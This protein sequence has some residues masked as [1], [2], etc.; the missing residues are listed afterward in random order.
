M[1]SG[2]LK[3][4][5]L[6]QAKELLEG[7]VEDKA[8]LFAALDSTGSISEA[9]GTS[10]GVSSETQA[11]LDLIAGLDKAS[12]GVVE[13]ARLFWDRGDV[14]SLSDAAKQSSSILANQ[15]EEA[16]VHAFQT[17]LFAQEPTATIYGLISDGHIKVGPEE[18]K[19]RVLETLD[20]AISRGVNISKDH[21]CDLV[22]EVGLVDDGTGK[23]TRTFFHDLVRL[24]ALVRLP[25]DLDALL[26]SPFT[27]AHQ[28]AHTARSSFITAMSHYDLP[29]DRA[30][31]IHE[32]ATLVDMRN[33]QVWAALMASR[34]DVP[35][36]A[37]G[38]TGAG[39]SKEG[40]GE[41]QVSS[42]KH[43]A[44]Y[45]DMFASDM[46]FNACDDCNS[47]TSPAA[48]FVD[49]LRML[50]NTLS[51]ASK[52]D[53]PTLLGKLG[54]RR[55]DLLTLQLSCVNTNVLIPYIDLA[56]EAME[57]FISNAGK[58]ITGY[59][60]TDQ[61]SSEISLSEP[62]HT[63]Y[64]VYSGQMANQTFPLTLFPY[65]QA[66]DFQRLF[67]SNIDTSLA[68]IIRV[69]GSELKLYRAAA[70]GENSPEPNE[71]Q[72]RLCK[73]VL[74]N[75]AAAEYL[76]LS[77][78]DYLII[79]GTS[80][81][82]LDFMKA[83]VDS[84]LDQ[85]A[86][87][88]K[89]GLQE[90]AKYWGYDSTGD[91]LSESDNRG[92]PFVKAQLLVRAK[93][94]VEQLLELLKARLLQNQL[95][96][97]NPDGSAE[98]SGKI[99][100]LRLRH[101][102]KDNPKAPI[103]EDDCH[104]LQ[105]TI[106]MWRKT[107]WTLQDLDCALVSFGAGGAKSGYM[108]SPK[109][110]RAMA[111]IQRISSLT[112]VEISRLMPL[113]GPMDTN[114]D[115]SLYARLFLRGKAQRRDSVFGPDD[116][117]NYLQAGD[118]L[119]A[120]R[121]PLLA[122]FALDEKSLLAIVAFLDIADDKLDLN[123]VTAIY[124]VSLFC[125]ILSIKG[126]QFASFQ[127]LLKLEF[128]SL[129]DPET[130]L[131]VIKTF[132]EI[133]QDAG[134][135][136]EQLLLF[137]NNDQG[138]LA[139]S[140]EI[141]HG[142][143]AQQSVSVASDLILGIQ[144]TEEGLP[145]FG[146]DNTT[147]SPSD[148]VT[149]S[150]KLFDAPTA[151]Q[152]DAFIEMRSGTPLTDTSV[153]YTNVLLPFF[154][155]PKEAHKIFFEQADPTTGTE[156]EK[157]IAREKMLNSRRVYFL[158]A[159]LS[160]LQTRLANEAVLQAITSLFSGADAD[161]DVSV[162]RRLLSTVKKADS[163]NAAILDVLTGLAASNQEALAKNS[164][165]V[166][167][168]PLVADS[169]R[170][171]IPATRPSRSSSPQ[172]T[173]DGTALVFEPANGGWRSGQVSLSNGYAYHLHRSDGGGLAGASFSTLR[174]PSNQAFPQGTLV[175]SETAIS[176]Q[177]QLQ[178]LM[179]G[180]YVCSVFELNLDEVQFFQLE[181]AAGTALAVDFG[182]V[183]YEAVRRLQAYGEL[184]AK[185]KRPGDLLD[186]LKWTANSARTG[187]LAGQIA[188]ILDVAERQV[189]EYLAQRFAGQKEEQMIRQFQGTAEL[190]RL[191]DTLSF[192]ARAGVPG[193]T[194][195]LLFKLATPIVPPTETSDF[196]SA[197]RLR[198][199]LR[200]APSS[201]NG[202]SLATQV[203]GELRKNQ[204]AALVAYLLQQPCIVSRGIT[205]ADGLFEFLLIDVQ[206]G[207]CLQTSRIKQAISTIQL[208]V[209]RCILGLEKDEQVA[210][211]TV[212]L[213]RWKWMEG[214][215]LWE[216]NRKV[217]L[218]PENW[219]EA[220]LR[221][222][223]TEVFQALESAIMQN[224]IN[225]E[226]IS[227][228][229]K[230]YVYGVDNIADLNVQAYLW[231]KGTE[232]YTGTFHFFGRTRTAPYIHYYRTLD[233]V[234]SPTG[235]SIKVFWQ[236]WTKIDIQI[237]VYESDAEGKLLK[238][239]GSYLIPALYGDRLFLFC[240]HISVKTSPSTSSNS[241]SPLEIG[242]KKPAEIR[243][244]K[245]WQMQIGWTELR[246]GKWTPKQVS[247]ATLEIAGAQ[248]SVFPGMGTNPPGSA[249]T[250]AQKLPDI[251]SFKFW[252][253][254]R[255]I[256]T[257]PSPPPVKAPEKVNGALQASTSI[258]VIDVERW[259]DA[260]EGQSHRHV[261]YPLGRFEMRGSAGQVVLVDLNKAADSDPFKK[262]WRPTIPTVFTKMSYHKESSSDRNTPDVVIGRGESD[263]YAPQ[264]GVVSDPVDKMAKRD[265]Q[266][267][268]SFDDA[269]K[270][271]ATG[272]FQD[273]ITTESTISYITYPPFDKT[274]SAFDVFQH[275]LDRD[276]ISMA[277]TYDGV[278]HIYSFLA[279][280]SQDEWF[281]A[282]GKRNKLVN[283]LSTPY[284]I[285]NWELGAHAV[286]LLMERLQ[287]TQQYDLALQVAHYV[288]DPTIDGDSLGRC[289]R[290]PP[291]RELAEA[292]TPI[293][294]VRE[295]LQ[296]LKP[297]SGAEEEM[298]TNILQ[299]RMNPFNPHNVARGRPQ[300]YMR[301]FVMKYIEILVASGDVYFRQNTLEA[302]PLAINRYVE[303]SHV[304]GSAPVQ[305]PALTKPVYK[306][307]ADL[308][309]GWNDFSNANM[310]LELDFPFYSD[311]AT[312]GSTAAAGKGN[313]LQGGGVTGILKSTYF[314]VPANPKLMG[315]RNLIDD[316][317]FKIRNCQDINGLVRNL[318]LFEP[319]LDPGLLVRATA[320]GADISKLVSNL[321]GPMPNYRFQYLLQR[322]LEMCAEVKAMGST[323][324]SIKEK[325]DAEALSNLR[326]RQDSILQT[327]TVDLRRTAK[328]E[329]ESSIE[330]LLE[331]RRAQVA[332]LEY[333]LALTGT[334]DKSAPG[335]TDEWEDIAQSIE[336]PTT[337]DLRMTSYEKLEMEKADQSAAINQG[338]TAVEIAASYIKLV[339]DIGE[340][341]EPMGVGVNIGSVTRNISESMLILAH[342]M[343][344]QGQALTDEGARASRTGNLVK[345]LQE[346]RFQANSAGRDIKDTD[347]QI[348]T[349]RI[350][351]EMCERDMQHQL[352]QAAYA[353]D[354]EDWLRTKYTSEQ[355]YAWMD[356]VVQNLYYQS[357]L[358]ADDLA[359]KA[360]AAFLFEK[361]VDRS[362][363]SSKM[364]M[365]PPTTWDGNKDGL[366]AGEN[367]F[368][369][370]KR[371]E[372]CY[373]ENRFHDVEI[374]KNIALR[375]IN[376]WALITLR[377]TG[378]AEFDLPEVLFDFDF[379]GHY[380]R[381]IKTVSLTL[382]C[383]VGPFT[384][385]NATLTLVSHRYRVSASTPSSSS[386]PQTDPSDPRFQ[387]D[388]IPIS[389]IAI[390]AGQQDTGLFSLDFKDER[391]IPFEGAG[392]ISRWRLELPTAIQQFDYNT[393]RD[394]I[395]HVK[396]TAL[397]GGAAFRKAAS[398][399]AVAFHKCAAEASL[400][401]LSSFSGTP[402]GEGGLFAILDLSSDFPTEW[403]RGVVET[404]DDAERTKVSTMPLAGLRERFLPF[405][406]KGWKA[407]NAESISVLVKAGNCGQG[408]IVIGEDIKL[409]VVGGSIV[410][411]MPE[412]LPLGSYRMATWK[413]KKNDKNNIKGRQARRTKG[414]AGSRRAQF[415][416]VEDEGE[417]E[418][419]LED[420]PVPVGDWTLTFSPKALGA[421]LEKVL[422][423]F[424]YSM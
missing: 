93:I 30:L 25:A 144:A 81:F 391:Y 20:K 98:F 255:S 168:K 38:R 159:I 392:L 304:F 1:T 186:F 321:A 85:K 92:L 155:D 327:L 116:Q 242:G 26:Q 389:S 95:V 215:R 103:T 393:I 239:A 374:T 414:A 217:F 40:N 71:E 16:A 138:K 286:M 269:Q 54:S 283:E 33:E 368:L 19:S 96:L 122:A 218:Y 251:S 332:R 236:P 296:A 408:G 294:S 343:R 405:F 8:L 32:H 399:S 293:K 74:A 355:L 195:E 80:I 372:T 52:K 120:N 328:Q 423:V 403:Y 7:L 235:L 410:K 51:D 371:L 253:R 386:Y 308:D 244:G 265:I 211:N 413:W 331:T 145:K 100:D 319:P 366:F 324:L 3:G 83:V 178:T 420:K 18:T 322:A 115:K 59:N 301:R 346:R 60:M 248:A 364:M 94:S 57:S 316:R 406:T 110:I 130:A 162:L 252:I 55:P 320:S 335:E 210:S 383:I 23:A 250:E 185:T 31:F 209:R 165:D 139:A 68:D 48:Y 153:T 315:L 384:G 288:F 238:E 353:K 318:P 365:I 75:A 256:V 299:W 42:C 284:A 274:T 21:A 317:L 277:T 35:I 340:A 356:G 45:S 232:D 53:S 13:L 360:Q 175:A 396:Y 97:E 270:K 133:T 338:A 404:R 174:T 149:A 108:A 300:A 194:L 125:Q 382:P 204:R 230:N 224:D 70:G 150:T 279:N 142:L 4:G 64:R 29:A 206:M 180:V 397:Q 104:L 24:Q 375:Q 325:K 323:L 128:E 249:W 367:L 216:A 245:H 394:V 132:Q 73:G 312:R 9:I 369:S 291:F 303:A 337:D 202:A 157:A 146:I 12:G 280:V 243:P 424:R 260:G 247:Q 151:Q 49:L 143:T 380:C 311:P 67:F 267:T 415:E 213:D 373:M 167:F 222:N 141:Y 419:T 290:F 117:G 50:K 113:W 358:L 379:P 199:L 2:R 118:S 101:P 314:C 198:L 36:A 88:K 99:E 378:I 377:E 336:K 342:V 212:D 411:L 203:S 281:L 89:I 147:A 390:S 289:W 268:M 183:S 182:E 201:G 58:T 37:L 176:V 137:T 161:A 298:N 258:L 177:T 309:K 409:A 227:D 5:Q 297:S 135:S 65:N 6:E 246:N 181:P 111:A 292:K 313:G 34:N 193:L 302:I 28:I 282:F 412:T 121:A 106:R 350:R 78:A 275:T 76:G 164:S 196:E 166:F 148:V 86:Y 72:L 345:Q 126:F 158:E 27:S 169:Y 351:V 43:M 129:Q 214:Y 47:V 381:R 124:R 63:D 263:N 416:K 295:I 61:D 123:N 341:A 109:A 363:S 10:A 197:A 105:S 221:D 241:D 172:V 11:R 398:D 330:A 171:Y 240:P 131:D 278:K 272:F 388:T 305:I 87:E 402:L 254:T 173:L 387:T 276:L 205:D 107:G 156:E 207:P 271:K 266:W 354:T 127:A 192:T 208:Y 114:G 307:Y 348:V 344:F 17:R 219:L 170:F 14:H 401:S 349:A 152:V 56:N 417:G 362:S 154:S 22:G 112:G 226:K 15:G 233:I 418:D 395:M 188:A 134:L 79:T 41:N 262:L 90:T 333:Y 264:F 66:L 347:R 261:N 191:L 231:K 39:Q 370:L 84:S 334:T 62:Q 339:P 257:P 77:P 69:F 306:S 407:V 385:V 376:P 102:V 91:M 160:P 259:V 200:S 228:L 229:I 422:V 357:Y 273:I 140:K 237:P 359:Q 329:A 326:C 223:K 163:S 287:A 234:V 400:S 220:S 285:Y 225:T 189:V 190:E 44:S 352:R 310:N 421:G 361:G 187:I 119:S 46:A 179:R 184:S 82:S 136:F